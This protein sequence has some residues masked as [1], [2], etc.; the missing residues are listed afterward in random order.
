MKGAAATSEVEAA[1][2][3]IRKFAVHDIEVLTLG[4]GVLDEVTRVIRAVI[5]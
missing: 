3:E 1:A 5:R 4:E 2:K